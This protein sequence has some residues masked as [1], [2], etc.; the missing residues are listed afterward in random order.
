MIKTIEIQNFKSVQQ[1]I[2]ELGRIN[3]FIGENGCGKSNLLEGI[4]LGAAAAADKLDFLSAYGIRVTDPDNFMSGFGKSLSQKEILIQFTDKNHKNFDFSIRAM[5][6]EWQL[7]SELP[8]HKIPLIIR[9]FKLY[10]PENHFLRRFE[11]EIQIK[12][13]GIRGEGLFSHL[14]ELAKTPS[15]IQK[16]Q[17]QLELIDWF[18]GFDIPPDLLFNEHRIRLRDRFLTD[19]LGYFDQRSANEGFLYILFYLTLLLSPKTPSFFAIDN[20][21][22]ALNPKL[23]TKLVKIIAQLAKAQEKQVLFIAH[24]PAILDGLDLKEDE[25][26][27]FVVSR[28]RTGETQ[29]SRILHKPLSIGQ[30]PVRLSEHFMN[31]AIGGLPK[32]F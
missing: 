5:D 12:P 4:A 1:V 20:L 25:H 19:G 13:L 27:L 18:D 10:A 14:V 24:N 26:R 3:V 17:D 6:N 32:N 15:I 22:N 9:N 28:S 23:C 30:S 21:D 29:V 7:Q 31:G 2:L 8:R 11:E 16:I